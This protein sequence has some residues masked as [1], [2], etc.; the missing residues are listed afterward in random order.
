MAQSFETNNALFRTSTSFVT[1]Q[2]AIVGIAVVDAIRREFVLSIAVRQS[3]FAG[4]DVEISARRTSILNYC[5]NLSFS[6]AEMHARVPCIEQCRY[7][8]ETQVFQGTRIAEDLEE[9]I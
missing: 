3:C 2:G 9:L 1:W 8:V 4:A 6:Q 5:N 7:A